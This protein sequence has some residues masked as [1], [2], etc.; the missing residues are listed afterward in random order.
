MKSILLSILLTL[1][2]LV[3]AGLIYVYSG[4]F[5]PSQTTPH[6]PLTQWIINKTLFTAIEKRVKDIRVPALDDTAMIS[7]GAS[8][9]NEMCVVCHGA[10]G[11]DPSE[12]VEG[13]N[14]KPPRILRPEDIVKAD[15]AFWIIKNGIKMTSMPAFAPTHNDDEIWAITAFAV[16]KMVRMS[17]S[18][19]QELTNP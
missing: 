13:L 17:P 12:L 15:E 1:V 3:I 4:I 8:H 10:P 6:K 19:Y 14:P 5:D 2:V 16:N 11:V 9:Y 7:L 18:E